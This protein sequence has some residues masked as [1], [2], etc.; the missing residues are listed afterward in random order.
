M[1]QWRRRIP[2]QVD[3][4]GIIQIMGTSL[5]SRSDTPIRELLQNAH[6]AIQRRRSTELSYKGRIDI[7]TLAEERALEFSDD[8]IGLTAEEA[9]KYLGTL[10]IGITGLM[11][12][13]HPS[14]GGA[15]AGGENLI[16]QFGIGLFSAFLLADRIIVESRKAGCD[17]AVRWI[18]GEGTDIQ[19]ESCD[20][21]AEGTSIRLMLKP[22]YGA[23]AENPQFIETAVREYADYL[24]VPIYLNGAS[25]RIN[26]IN[27]AWFEPTPD[28][29]DVEL[30]LQEKFSETPLDV[31]PIR[32]ESPISIAGALYVTPQRTPGFAG[33]PVL[34]TT[35][36]RMVISRS[37]LGLLPQWATFLRGVLELN[38]CSPT[39]SREDLVRDAKFDLVRTELEKALFEHFEN[40]AVSDPARMES[41]LSWHRYTFSGAALTDRRLRDLLRGTYKFT[42]SRGPLTCT[43]II[44]RSAADALF[45][46]EADRVLWVNSDRRQERWVNSL[47]EDQDVPCVHALRSFEESLL[48]AMAGDA[49]E[50]SGEQIDVR[51]AG[52]G[53]DGFGSQILGMEDVT[54]APQV[55]QE[56]LAAT[57]ARI[58]TA[59]FRSNQPV[60]AFLNNRHELQRTYEELKKQGTVPSGFQRLIDAHFGEG[61]TARH[62]V[63]LNRRHR[64]VSRVLSQTTG[65]PLASVL[66]MLVVSSLVSAG[67][68]VPHEVHR[69]ESE[70]LDWIAEA[71]WG[72]DNGPA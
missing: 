51:M 41:V 42:T 17:E 58:M 57:E 26:V 24:T 22:E 37:T 56:Y 39:A 54:D 19:L 64:L 20:R 46:S 28:A 32:K 36:K 34:M 48:A 2:F 70:D 72:R 45:E 44:N 10:G 66:R 50:E 29:E 60:M 67:A 71:L 52:P 9:E 59:T 16:G 5:Y 69:Q 14:S 31:I 6:D 25:Q 38:D 4:A 35:I 11:K 8:G 27:A 18:A 61:E 68:S 15:V 47:F 13:R 23:L 49:A 33:D 3:V 53:S 12:G 40:I 63:L 1:A 7:R 65:T 30:A 21:A 62:E 55:W 43:E